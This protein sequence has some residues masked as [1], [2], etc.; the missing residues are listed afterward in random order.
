M[1]VLCAVASAPLFAQTQN[2][3]AAEKALPVSK[4]ISGDIP[5]N[6]A[7]VK[8]APS[9]GMYSVLI[10]EGWARTGN[11]NN[12]LFVDK[13]NGV[14]LQILPFSGQFSRDAVERSF[15]PELVKNGRAVTVK[16]VS[17]RQR[18]GGRAVAIAF[19]SNSEPN[20][21]TGK[22]VRI[23]NMAYI[24]YSKGNIMVMTLWAPVGSDNVDQW[25]LMSDSFR[26]R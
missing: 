24:F 7:F 15:V 19:D 8:Y 26:W 13:Y 4:A 11:P 17:E 10:P 20:S 12:V 16:K 5:D 2:S 14:H 22:Q 21:V 6:Q 3:G 18:K 1:L 23:E 25:N 9:D